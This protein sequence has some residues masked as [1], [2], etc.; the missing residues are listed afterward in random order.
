[1]NEKSSSPVLR[2]L[3]GSNASRLPDTL[4]TAT[5]M[6][7]SGNRLSPP[8]FLDTGGFDG[9]QAHTRRH[10]DGLKKKVAKLEARRDQFS[11][12]DPKREPSERKLVVLRQEIAQCW[13]KYE[14]RNNDLA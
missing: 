3:R 1:M 11:V 14:A 4:V 7:L 6:D 9:R 8:L 2:G 13:R 12:G 5:V 10:I